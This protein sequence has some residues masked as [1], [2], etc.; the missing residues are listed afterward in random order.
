[1]TQNINDPDDIS[2]HFDRLFHGLAPR[3]ASL[4]NV[5]CLHMLHDGKKKRYLFM[6]FK[7]ESEQLNGGMRWAYRDLADLPNVCVVVIWLIRSAPPRYI[8]TLPDIDYEM[9]PSISVEE[10]QSRYKTW[11][12]S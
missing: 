6:E 8:V 9:T 12:V 11:W 3:G 2:N 1:V 7:E 4:S 10:L 5:D